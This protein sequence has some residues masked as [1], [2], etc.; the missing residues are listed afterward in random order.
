MIKHVLK[1]TLLAGILLVMSQGVIASEGG[2]LQAAHTNMRDIAGLQHGAKLFM[3]YCS[4]CHSLQ[5][6]RYSRMA[7]D[8][9]LTEEEVME[10]L[11]FTGAKFQEPIISAMPA[12]DAQTWFGK[13]PPDLSLEVRAKGADWVYSYLHGFYLDPSRPVGWNNTVFPNASMPNVLA[14]LQGI[15]KAVHAKADENGHSPIEKLELVQAGS[16][17]PAQFDSAVRDLTGFLQYAAEPA[18]MQR[19]SMGIWVILY[20]ALFTLL[21]FF[22]KKEFW[23]DIH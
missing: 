4:S 18:A 21:A 11:N 3:N 13:A 6:L 16:M 17:T 20:L 9:H 23:K 2:K 14:S 12:A 5:Y 8:L 7:S 15:Q 22:L 19:T 1:S 10:N